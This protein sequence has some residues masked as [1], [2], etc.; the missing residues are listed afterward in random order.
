MFFES[1]FSLFEDNE[2]VSI[3][4]LKKNFKNKVSEIID[5]SSK[6]TYENKQLMKKI[7]KNMISSYLRLLF[8]RKK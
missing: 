1:I 3:L 7:I 4:E 6:I 5:S 2:I 8:N